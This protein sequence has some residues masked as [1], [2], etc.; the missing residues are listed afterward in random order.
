MLSKGCDDICIISANWMPVGASWAIPGGS[1]GPALARLW[2]Q[3]DKRGRT[4][5]VTTV[6]G[7]GWRP[8]ELPLC[9]GL[10]RARHTDRI[11]T[12]RPVGPGELWQL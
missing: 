6:G 7:V 2:P 8:V 5:R 12:D 3:A 9:P 11:H 4:G 1:R 10:F